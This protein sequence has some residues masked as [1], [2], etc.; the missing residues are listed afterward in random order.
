MDEGKMALE[1]I[2]IVK[3]NN[4]GKALDIA[5]MSRDMHGGNGIQ[6]EYHVMRH[7]SNFETVS[8]VSG[9]RNLE[10]PDEGSVRQRRLRH[11][12]RYH[13]KRGHSARR[14]GH[15]RAFRQLV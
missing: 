7:L 12:K 14:S 5:R 3:R 1:M 6:I 2:S 9:V 11:E 8:V 15:G 10:S 4:C 13:D